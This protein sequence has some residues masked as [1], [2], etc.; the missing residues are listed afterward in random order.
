MV[1]SRSEFYTTWVQQVCSE[2]ETIALYSYHRQALRAHL[3]MR[4]STSDYITDRFQDYSPAGLV[5]GLLTSQP[6][7]KI[8]HQLA[9]FEHYSPIWRFTSWPGLRITHQ[10]AWSDDYSPVWG[11]LTS[12]SGYRIIHQLAWFQDYWPADLV[13]GLLTSWP[14]LRITH[15]LAW[16]DNYSPAGLVSG[17]L[18]SWPGLT[19]T[20]QLAQS[21]HYSPVWG[22]LTSWPGLRITH[23]PAWSQDYSPV[24]WLFTSWPGLTITHQQV[25]Q[26]WPACAMSGAQSP[27]AAAAGRRRRTAS[28]WPT[29]TRRGR[30]HGKLPGS[31]PLATYSAKSR[32][33]PQR[34]SQ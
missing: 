11:L 21:D 25:C 23:Q 14:G 32:Q 16:S 19:T 3:K 24:W 13:W 34:S 12:W 5:S 27:L 20:H 33:S 7:L 26:R 2:A 6:G 8:T 31:H 28:C 17:L 29:G 4:P 18:T 10:L 22:L 15:Q 30:P 1:S 9:W